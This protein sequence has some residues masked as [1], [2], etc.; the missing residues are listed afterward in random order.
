MK[1]NDF[2]WRFSDKL[3]S[4]PTTIPTHVIE[5]GKNESLEQTNL[6]A[7]TQPIL[8]I[9]GTQLRGKW[10]NNGE[11][12]EGPISDHP[13]A[14]VLYVTPDVTQAHERVVYGKK[15][16]ES[17]KFHP[18]QFVSAAAP[19][20]SILSPIADENQKAFK[21]LLQSYNNSQRDP[22]TVLTEARS[23]G[24]QRKHIHL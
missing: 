14:R 19:S 2:E 15:D 22:Q 18:N 24:D 1:Q 12:I 3:A 20:S 16:N 11:L 17:D 6:D 4:Q 13:A 21:M 9:I 5:T 10:N 8:W 23:D 7:H